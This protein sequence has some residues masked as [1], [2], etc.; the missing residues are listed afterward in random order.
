MRNQS[1]HWETSER[2]ASGEETELTGKY[3]TLLRDVPSL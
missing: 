2:K 3:G 1:M